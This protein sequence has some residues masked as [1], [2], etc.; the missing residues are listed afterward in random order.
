MQ[1]NS[2]REFC[3]FMPNSVDTKGFNVVSKVLQVK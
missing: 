1:L 3:E 2:L